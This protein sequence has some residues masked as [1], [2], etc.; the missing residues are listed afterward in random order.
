VSRLRRIGRSRP[1]HHKIVAILALGGATAYGVRQVLTR[2]S[3][4][5]KLPVGPEGAA[6]ETAIGERREPAS[7]SAAHRSTDMPVGVEVPLNED[8]LV[9][10]EEL[11][12]LLKA[13]RID[14]NETNC[15]DATTVV[16]MPGGRISI[17]VITE[18]HSSLIA[19]FDL[20]VGVQAAS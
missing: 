5:A 7:A 4:Q 13:A 8:Q 6:I 9:F 12:G 1:F 15:E 3:L 16:V 20:L 10:G 17:K 2:S 18:D 19:A 14:G 11:D